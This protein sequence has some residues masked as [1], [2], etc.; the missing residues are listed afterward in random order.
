MNYWRTAGVNDSGTHTHGLGSGQGEDMVR[1]DFVHQDLLDNGYLRWDYDVQLKDVTDPNVLSA[2]TLQE[3]IKGKT[4]RR[5]Y[6]V[7]TKGNQQPQ[8]GSY[9][10]GDACILKIEDPAHPDGVRFPTRIIGWRV[11]PPSGST[12]EKIAVYFEG[13]SGGV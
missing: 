6:V 3:A 10:Q 2:L 1:A 12:L 11:T 7:E 5:T 8:F 4:P 9:L 13:G